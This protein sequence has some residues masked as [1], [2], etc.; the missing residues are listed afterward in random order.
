MPNIFAKLNPI[1]DIAQELKAKLVSPK[2]VAFVELILP[3]LEHFAEHI[4]WS[5][6]ISDFITN[7]S[8]NPTEKGAAVAA[9]AALTPI[10]ISAEAEAKAE[11]PAVEKELGI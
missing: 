3:A 2:L 7:Y 9:A 11:L 6:V 5:K 4:D 10:L 8:K 1:H